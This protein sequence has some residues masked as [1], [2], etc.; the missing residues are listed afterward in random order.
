MNAAWSSARCE[1]LKKPPKFVS[2]YHS[3]YDEYIVFS[4]FIFFLCVEQGYRGGDN[5]E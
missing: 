1:L 3:L 2:F 4:P 5:R